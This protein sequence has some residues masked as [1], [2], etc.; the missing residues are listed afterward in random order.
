MMIYTRKELLIFQISHLE[1]SFRKTNIVEK[2]NFIQ[3]KIIRMYILK[4]AS[5]FEGY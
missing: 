4:V 2:I 3:S 1:K 5:Y